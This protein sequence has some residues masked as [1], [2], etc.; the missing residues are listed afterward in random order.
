M[1]IPDL[2]FNRSGPVGRGGQRDRSEQFV[3]Q[4]MAQE[5][6]TSEAKS[7]SVREPGGDRGV[8]CS[9]PAPVTS[10]A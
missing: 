1:N 6:L 4:Q 2:D 8:E 5:P 7:A 9:Q 3:C 10:A